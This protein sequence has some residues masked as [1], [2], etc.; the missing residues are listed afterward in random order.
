MAQA[1]RTALIT[2]SGKNIGRAIALHLAEAGHNIVINGSRDKA[3][4][5]EVAGKVR[6]LGAQAMIQMGDIGDRAAVQAMAKAAIDT[7]GNVDILIN[8]AA[9]RPDGKYLETDETEWQRI[10]DINFYSVFH[11]TRACLPGMIAKGWGRIVNF[12]GMNA[13]QGY[14]GKSAAVAVSKHAAW[15][16]TKSLSREFGPQ[17]ITANIISPGTI[18]GPEADLASPRLE[19]LR[20]ANP[21]RR[22]GTADD[23]AAMVDLLVSDQGGFVNGQMLQVNGGVVNQF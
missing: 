23:I 3:A 22:L 11:L 2:G 18:P 1:K 14:P 17:G 4:C 7:F 10:M 16:L 13:Q 5:E 9:V 20:K 8:N 6:E 15:G 19:S 21:V 12:T